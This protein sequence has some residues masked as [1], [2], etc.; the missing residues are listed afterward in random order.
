MRNNENNYFNSIFRKGLDRIAVPNWAAFVDTY[1]QQINY[2]SM[3]PTH[4]IY[5]DDLDESIEV[6]T[7]PQDT[8][9]VDGEEYS[10]KQVIYDPISELFNE[11]PDTAVIERADEE[12]QI[13]RF[14]FA[15]SYYLP[16]RIK[17]IYKEEDTT[18]NEIE[19]G[20]LVEARK[21]EAIVHLNFTELIRYWDIYQTEEERYRPL[22]NPL[23][24]RVSKLNNVRYGDYIEVEPFSD[25]IDKDSI[26][27]PTYSVSLFKISGARIYRIVDIKPIGSTL[28]KNINLYY[29]AAIFDRRIDNVSLYPLK[30]L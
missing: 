2:Y 20:M 3:V 17:G 13:T 30:K 9:T 23:D 6:P 7:E 12:S 18:I 29:I 16:Y 28:F 5:R 11:I 22:F 26:D 25:L 27:F 24:P 1:G 8:I 21:L 10:N 14:S 19:K 15:S 4:E